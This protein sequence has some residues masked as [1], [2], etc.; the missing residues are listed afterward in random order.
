MP[1]ALKQIKD[2]LGDDA[3]ILSSKEQAGGITV[4]AAIDEDAME[5]KTSPL[6]KKPAVTQAATPSRQ[7]ITA[8][9]LRFDVQNCLRFHGIPEHFLA[10]MTSTLTEAATAHI[11]A[12][13]RLNIADESKHFLKLALEHIAAQYFAFAKPISHAERIMLVGTPGIGKT[14][15]AAKMATA[16]ALSH[17]TPVVISCDISRAGGVEQLKAFTDILG[18]D[19]LLCES[20][21]ELQNELRNIN[22]NTPVIVDTAGCNAYDE[23]AMDELTALASLTGIEPIL[24][25][26]SGM[27]SGEALDI[28]EA[29]M[30]MP[31]HRMIATRTDSARRFG[32]MISVASAHKLA[33]YLNS[34][35]ASVTEG[36]EPFSPAILAQLL[37]APM[38]QQPT[39]KLEKPKAPLF[40]STQTV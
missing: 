27:D 31:I 28:S 26:A 18:I 14:L 15:A 19:I 3:I 1:E 12:R 6:V 10:K 17:T 16:Y 32:S 7:D 24:V 38:L 8:H 13:S 39:S 40:H 29:F 5:K 35:S 33:L 30:Q 9:Q 37:I 11:L 20:P 34:S 23:A 21:R 36:L 25:M 22:K 2:A 4:T